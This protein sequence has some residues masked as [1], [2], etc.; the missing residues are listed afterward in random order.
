M[1]RRIRNLLA[2]AI[3]AATPMATVLVPAVA[4]AAVDTCTW[5]G[6]VDNTFSNGGNW[7][8]CDNGGVPENGDSLVFD[9]SASANDPDNDMSSMSF[10]D[11]SFIGTGGA[12]ITMTGN[13]FTITGDVNDS[14]DQANTIANNV[15]ITG[16]THFDVVDPA[17]LDFS[18][19]VAGS[20]SII[21]NGSGTVLLEDL[22]L[23]GSLTVNDGVVNV[24]ATGATDATVSSVTVATGAVF[25]YDA[26]GYS[27]PAATYTL[28]T[29]INSDGGILDFETLG[30]SG[31][32]A[33]NL[34]GT[35]TLTANTDVQ[36]TS[37]TVVHVQGSL[38]GPTFKLTTANAGAVLN[39]STDNTSATPA[40]DITSS[41]TSG[42]TSGGGTT[43]AAPDTG[44]ALV[45]A[46][47]AVSMAITVLAA[48]SILA[49]AR[50]TRNATSRR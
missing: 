30:G 37:G 7:S 45:S 1:L 36:V 18:G 16:T 34:T 50:L 8:V 6:A 40:G 28:S 44:F 3:L 17:L 43:P 10:A 38:H 47:P 48:G 9:T 2:A 32:F 42:G 35:I 29:P 23:T 4:H 19:T 20:G 21:S 14:S 39:E 46:H 49:I 24:L 41:G 27:T 33:L 26:F 12:P 15:T 22:T 5:T 13:G 25:G 11:V 31:P